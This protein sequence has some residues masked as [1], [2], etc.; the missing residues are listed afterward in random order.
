MFN[1]H[2]ITRSGSSWVARRRDPLTGRRDIYKGYGEASLKKFL[3]KDQMKPKPWSHGVIDRK[4]NVAYRRNR[5]GTTI[6]GTGVRVPA[7]G[8]ILGWQKTKR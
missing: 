4:N 1:S 6:P 3:G 7:T 5:W 8:G 2:R